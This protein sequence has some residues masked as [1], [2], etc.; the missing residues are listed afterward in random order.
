[1]IHEVTKIGVLTDSRYF[2]MISIEDSRTLFVALRYSDHDRGL[3]TPL[4]L[5]RFSQESLWSTSRYNEWALT[6]AAVPLKVLGGFKTGNVKYKRVDV[7]VSY[8]RWW[9][10]RRTILSAC[11]I[12]LCLG[13][14]AK[15]W[16]VGSL[17]NRRMDVWL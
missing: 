11:S 14:V 6:E 7:D 15:L 4:V 2:H 3:P 16:Y 13:S 5:K 8:S 10:P 12:P 1:M 17:G 9:M